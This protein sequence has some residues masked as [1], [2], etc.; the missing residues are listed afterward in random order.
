MKSFFTPH[1]LA[2]ACATLCGLL[3]TSAQAQS[4]VTLFG[5]VDLSVQSVKSDGAGSATKMASGSNQTS[6]IGFRGTEDLGGGLSAGFWLEG[7]LALNAGTG[8]ANNTNNQSTGALSAS[9]LQ[10]DRRATLSLSNSALG[11]LRIGRDYTPT[12]WSLSKADPFFANGLGADR[13]LIGAGA[14]S[15]PTIVRASNSIGYHLPSDLGGV[16]GQAM[17]A[18]GNNASNVANAN[19]GQ[20]LGARLGFAK[21]GWDVAGATS[22]T[23]YLAGDFQI[24][25]LMLAYDAGFVRVSALLNQSTLKTPVQQKQKDYLLAA[26]IPWGVGEFKASYVKSDISTSPKGAG[27]KLLALGYLHNLSKRSAAYVHY[28]RIANTG[29]ATFTNNG[30]TP[31]GGGTA[32]GIEVG[33]RH[34]F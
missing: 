33:L 14:I 11:E 10:F 7:G 29:G 9:G 20:Y 1:P 31:S 12:Y 5:V 22:T 16:Y 27:A 3:C 6:R 15:A 32:K 26:S 4:S 23:K 30:L 13:N 19:D 21:Q 18:F 2:T 25:N 8:A 28:G 34:F 17:A 24:S